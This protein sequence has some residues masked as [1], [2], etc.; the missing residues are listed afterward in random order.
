MK[1]FSSTAFKEI[2]LQNWEQ[3]ESIGPKKTSNYI[4]YCSSLTKKSFH[5]L[6]LF[7][8]WASNSEYL[9]QIN[10]TFETSLG[11]ES[12][13]QV[14]HF[15]GEKP[16]VNLIQGYLLKRTNLRFDYFAAF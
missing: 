6:Q 15:S 10:F 2:L 4:F 13:D 12:W 14:G 16:E 1:L 9:F 3:G 8:E 5:I 7:T 11:Y